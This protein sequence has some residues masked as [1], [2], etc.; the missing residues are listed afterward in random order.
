MGTRNLTTVIN[1]EGEKKDGNWR[2][3]GDPRCDAEVG[4]LMEKAR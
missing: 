1:Q 4:G 2:E 3:R